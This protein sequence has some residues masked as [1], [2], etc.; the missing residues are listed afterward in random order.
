MP[1]CLFLVPE[2]VRNTSTITLLRVVVSL[3]KH[4]ELGTVVRLSKTKRRREE[5]IDYTHNT[6]FAVR[7]FKTLLLLYTRL[8]L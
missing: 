1:L 6:I 2:Q 3:L 5:K 4:A 7:D 8:S